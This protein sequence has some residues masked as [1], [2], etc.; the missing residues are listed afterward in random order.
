MDGW[1]D[2]WLQIVE[3][4]HS[5]FY[6]HIKCR[7]CKS[8][9]HRHRSLVTWSSI[10]ARN[11]LN[12]TKDKSFMT[13]YWSFPIFWPSKLSVIALCH[14]IAIQKI[15]PKYTIFINQYWTNI[16]LTWMTDVQQFVPPR[17]ILC[18]RPVINCGTFNAVYWR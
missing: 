2:G 10:Q 17:E 16:T 8:L 5:S 4:F 18:F 15:L 13:V 14:V 7:S 1:M 3:T 11:L 9:S 6:P 12:P